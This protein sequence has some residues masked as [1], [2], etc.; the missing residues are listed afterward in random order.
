MCLDAFSNTVNH[1]WPLQRVFQSFPAFFCPHIIPQLPQPFPNP[2]LHFQPLSLISMS[3]WPISTDLGSHN[4]PTHLYNLP[5]PFTSPTVHF[6][7]HT[8]IPDPK[9]HFQPFL[10]FPNRYHVFLRVY[11]FG[12]P[13]TSTWTRFRDCPPS[14]SN[15]YPHSPLTF[16]A[17]CHPFLSLVTHFS[18]HFCLFSSF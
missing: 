16:P 10:H 5:W 7:S 9:P 1:L 14:S 18:T 15:T 3:F 2:C 13:P 4:E 12:Q 6:W 17:I 8:L 11:E